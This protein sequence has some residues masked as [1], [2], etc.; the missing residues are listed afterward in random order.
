LGVELDKPRIHEEAP[1]GKGRI[2]GVFRGDSAT[3]TDGGAAT[4]DRGA[5]R[6][7]E[8]IVSTYPFGV[9]DQAASRHHVA[10]ERR[11]M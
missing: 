3:M 2:A 10:F 7:E 8:A 5:S 1:V 9:E 4:P 11:L 6:G